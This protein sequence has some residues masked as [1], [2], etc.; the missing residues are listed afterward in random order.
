MSAAAPAIAPAGTPPLTASSH[1]PT[2]AAEEA[3]V[4]RPLSDH[5]KRAYDHV[6]A[7]VLDRARVR[8]VPLLPPATAG[9]ALGR[10]VLV[11]RGREA[12]RALLAHELVH[13]RQ[14]HERGTVVFL[15]R[16]LGAYARGLVRTRR[17][18]AAYLAIPAEVEA[19]AEAAAWAE[20][21]APA[22]ARVGG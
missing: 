22:T 13:V 21:R 15:A 6:P 19:R 5:E 8:V 18:R 9:M 7:P 11:R 4:A 12:D 1:L 17:H 2:I 16:Y 20:R 14:W 10:W 3:P